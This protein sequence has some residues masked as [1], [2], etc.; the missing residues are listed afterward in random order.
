MRVYRC[1][2]Y[3]K[4]LGQLVSW[5]GSKRE[6]DQYLRNFQKERGGETVGPESVALEEIPTD[7]EGLLRW[8]N[9]NLSTDNG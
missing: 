6:A 2:C 3:D 8:L 5:H 1:N 9:A 4:D 7:K